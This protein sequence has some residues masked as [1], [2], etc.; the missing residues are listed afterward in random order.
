MD[1]L[2]LTINEI[3][4]RLASDIGLTKIRHLNLAGNQI[5]D[6][7]ALASLASLWYLDVKDNPISDIAPLTGLAKLGKLHI[8]Q[9]GIN[10]EQQDMLQSALPG[11]DITWYE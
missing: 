7:T 11:C 2:N 5:N 3:T 4:D 9:A 6:I 10:A 1:P 8:S